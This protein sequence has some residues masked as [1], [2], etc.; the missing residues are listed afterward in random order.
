[1]AVIEQA[2]TVHQQIHITTLK[3]CQADFAGK[4]FSSPSLVIVGEVVKLQQAFN[5][6]TSNKEGS[7]FKELATE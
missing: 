5:W 7:V 2:T 6:F 1:M 3:N 4:Q